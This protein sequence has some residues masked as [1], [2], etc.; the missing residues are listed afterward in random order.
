MFHFLIK[1]LGMSHILSEEE[2]L[3][4]EISCKLALACTLF[5]FKK[6]RE[7][8]QQS[9]ANSFEIRKIELKARV[10]A[11]TLSGNSILDRFVERC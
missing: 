10:L 3:K 7:E 6:Y 11:D 1:G 4:R 5:T 8:R 2:Q 9:Q